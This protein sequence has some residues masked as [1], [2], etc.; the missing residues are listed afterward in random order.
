MGSHRKMR[1]ERV[2]KNVEPAGRAQ[3]RPLLPSLEQVAQEK[4]GGRKRV[5]AEQHVLAA[6]VPVVAERMEERVGQGHDAR[7]AALG[8]VGDALV[9]FAIASFAF[10]DSLL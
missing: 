8:R 10:L 7:P 1:A 4:A 2:A 9:S 6:Q 3:P 5:V